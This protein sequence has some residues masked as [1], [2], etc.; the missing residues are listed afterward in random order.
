MGRS[1]TLIAEARLAGFSTTSATLE[2]TRQAGA[3]LTRE[4]RDEI[5]QRAKALGVRLHIR[6]YGSMFSAAASRSVR[7]RGPVT[8]ATPYEAAD[9]LL[10]AL[11]GPIG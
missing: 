9:V 4:Q 8:S 3:A 7:S 5:A 1:V 2:L 11:E 10:R 6:H